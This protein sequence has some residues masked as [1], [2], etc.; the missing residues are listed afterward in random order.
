MQHQDWS[1]VA[2]TISDF[3]DPSLI[4]ATPVVVIESAKA[5]SSENSVLVQRSG[6]NH[7][8]FSLSPQMIKHEIGFTRAR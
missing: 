2:L 5:T 4:G 7:Q 6:V 1:G 8:R 3:A